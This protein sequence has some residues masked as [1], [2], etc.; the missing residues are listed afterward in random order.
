M[1][2][3]SFWLLCMRGDLYLFIHLG[4]FCFL[5]SIF[6]QD[7]QVWACKSRVK[8]TPNFFIPPG[9]DTLFFDVV[10]LR[11]FGSGTNYVLVSVSVIIEVFE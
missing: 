5:A 10:L 7:S 8:D 4:N 3:P 11:F 6:R 2:L 1:S 9:K